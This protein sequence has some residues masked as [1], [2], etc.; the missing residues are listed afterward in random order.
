[1]D[2]VICAIQ[3]FIMNQTIYAYHNEKCIY[4]TIC[5]ISDL[6]NTLHFICK[7]Y[8]MDTIELGG[9]YTYANKIKD[10]FIA[11]KFEDLKD[12]KIKLV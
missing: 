3:P 5:N 4:K 7:E 12:I 10:D 6:V 8:N 1:M 11:T 2:R 9:S